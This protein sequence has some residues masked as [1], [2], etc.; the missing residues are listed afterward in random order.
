M[1]LFGSRAKGEETNESI[2]D[3]AL[4][5]EDKINPLKLYKNAQE[6]ACLL[7]SDVVLVD[8]KSVS[9]VFQFQIVSKGERIFCSDKYFCDTFDCLTCSFYQKLNEERRE[10]L[11]GNEN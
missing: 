1:Y 8:L 6:L 10:I 3:L 11:E 4:L 9:T 2:W 5:C 7:G